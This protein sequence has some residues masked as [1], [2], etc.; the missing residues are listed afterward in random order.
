MGYK[1]KFSFYHYYKSLNTGLGLALGLDQPSECWSCSS[2]SYFAC[3]TCEIILIYCLCIWTNNLTWLVIAQNDS[4]P[5]VEM[6]V[7][8]ISFVKGYKMHNHI[9]F[10]FPPKLYHRRDKIIVC[11]WCHMATYI[12]VNIDSGN[13]LL[14]DSTKP[15]PEPML[16]HYQRCSVAFTR[17]QSPRLQWVKS[18][19]PSNAI[20]RQGSRSTLVQV[21]GCCLTAPSHYPNQCW[22]II[23]KVLWHSLE[24]NIMRRSEDTN[25]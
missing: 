10:L 24:G 13:G 14:P 17:G 2:I 9:Y 20:W 22:L 3:L 18:L 7:K 21:M 15:L 11:Q 25:Q 19:W 5:E 12:W 23:S 8:S 16:I 1:W 4:M 6:S